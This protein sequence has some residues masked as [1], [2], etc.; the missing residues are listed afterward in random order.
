MRLVFSAVVCLVLFL[1]CQDSAGPNDAKTPTTKTGSE[2]TQVEETK[3]ADPAQCEE[4]K[5]SA[6]F[7]LVKLSLGAQM[8][9][10]DAGYATLAGPDVPEI[11]KI[12][13][14]EIHKFLQNLKNLPDPAE[15]SSVSRPSVVIREIEESLKLMEANF[16]AKTPFANGSGDGLRLAEQLE[17]LYLKSAM[18]FSEC[19]RECGC[20]F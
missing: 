12:D 14:A 15:H 6:T 13:P 2:M 4:W 16:A 19:A 20:S 7:V 5:N 1:G 11:S 9:R 3:P 18:S 8:L 17:A 10:D